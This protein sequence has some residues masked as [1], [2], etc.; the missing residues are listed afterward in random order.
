MIRMPKRWPLHKCTLE[1][2]SVLAVGTLLL[3]DENDQKYKEA[4]IVGR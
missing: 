2:S 4:R 3:G 1:L